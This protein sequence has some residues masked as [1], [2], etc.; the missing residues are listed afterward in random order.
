MF[1][2]KALQ[3]MG[4]SLEIWTGIPARPAWLSGEC[5]T[6]QTKGW[7]GAGWGW[8]RAGGGRNKSLSDHHP[9]PDT[10]THT[11][12]RPDTTTRAHRHTF[13]NVAARLRGHKT[14]AVFGFCGA[15]KRLLR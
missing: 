1:A 14:R 2:V 13:H 3:D 9:P 7:V 5:S 4:E 15:L 12:R 11:P 6:I 10:H 8:G